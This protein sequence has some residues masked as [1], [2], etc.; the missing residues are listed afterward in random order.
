MIRFETINV[1]GNRIT[2]EFQTVE[3]IS[4]DWHSDDCTLPAN[5]DKVIWA[6]RDGISIKATVFEDIIKKLEIK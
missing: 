5:D 3:E 6:D 4:N 2:R 1:D